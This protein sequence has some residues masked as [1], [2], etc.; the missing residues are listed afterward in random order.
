MLTIEAKNIT[1][2]F[3]HLQIIA[4]FSYQFKSDIIYGIVGNNGSGK[5]T[6]LKIIAGFITPNKGEVSY[7]FNQ[8]KIPVE[9]IY[10]QLS[11]IAPY[12]DLIEDFDIT[13]HLLFHFSHKKSILQDHRD[14]IEL[15][16]LPAHK[17]IKDFSSGMK[18][19]FKLTL[20][21]LTESDFLLIDEPGSF[22][23]NATKIYYNYL[24]QQFQ[25]NRMIIIASNE[26]NDLES[27]KEIINIEDY[28]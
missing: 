14:I 12:I 24:L 6:L 9:V 13:E 1:K 5:S 28:K 16:Q 21:I 18:Q 17:K 11:F 22:L 25:K 3:N 2:K 20:A 27:C 10:K 4:D 26:K 23:D 8:Q 15:M 19:K 7:H